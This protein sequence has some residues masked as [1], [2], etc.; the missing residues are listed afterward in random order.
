MP[1]FDDVYA[2]FMYNN[3]AESLG[4]G[5]AVYSPETD[6]IYYIGDGEE[7]EDTEAGQLDPDKLIYFANSYDLGLGK[8]LV[9]D[10]VKRYL[11]Q[12]Y[13]RVRSIFSRRGAYQ[14]WKN[15]LANRSLLDQ[16]Y[17]FENEKTEK[18]LRQWCAE[19]GIKLTD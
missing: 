3:S 2:A 15:F 17:Q 14:R 16:W 5:Y 1:T 12:D 7:L 18:A 9:F 4:I 8:A 19:V 11:P 10:F 13:D 6:K